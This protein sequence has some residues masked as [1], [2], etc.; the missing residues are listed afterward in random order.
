MAERKRSMGSV[1][2]APQILQVSPGGPLGDLKE[3]W[4]CFALCQKK[5]LFQ[6]DMKSAGKKAGEMGQVFPLFKN[7]T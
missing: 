1:S 3:R 5:H 6:I 7:A 4:P 2:L